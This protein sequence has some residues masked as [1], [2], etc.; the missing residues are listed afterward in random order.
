ML[1]KRKEKKYTKKRLDNINKIYE[2]LGSYKTIKTNKIVGDLKINP[3]MIERYMHDI[4]NLYHNIGYDYSKNE[5]YI[6]W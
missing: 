6:I 5:W 1:E 3:R 4:N 2:Y